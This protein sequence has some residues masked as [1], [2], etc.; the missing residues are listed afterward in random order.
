MSQDAPNLQP[1]Q[2][3]VIEERA[4]LHAKIEKL[5]A[6]L[7]SDTFR[8]LQIMDQCYLARQRTLMREYCQVLDFRI[9]RF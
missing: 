5:E 3:R 2:Q 7:D 1:H 8:E 4:E 6:F 9:A